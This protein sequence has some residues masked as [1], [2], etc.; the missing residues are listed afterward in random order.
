MCLNLINVQ[1]VIMYNC[2]I[3][4][5]NFVS[6][7]VKQKNMHSA[8]T[9]VVFLFLGF[10]AR[11]ETFLVVALFTFSFKTKKKACA[12]I[13]NPKLQYTRKGEETLVLL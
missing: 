1:N 11:C 8:C 9:F 4:C 10:C 7:K 12:T 6:T 3:V 13:S 5:I 2:V